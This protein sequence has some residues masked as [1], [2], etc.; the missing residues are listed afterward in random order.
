[1][2]HI[3]QRKLQRNGKSLILGLPF[4]A[5]QKMGVTAGDI[6]IVTYDDERDTLTFQPYTRGG[7]GPGVTVDGAR[8]ETVVMK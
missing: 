8:V 3:T 2:V 1:M 5:V 7:R 6:F 4:L